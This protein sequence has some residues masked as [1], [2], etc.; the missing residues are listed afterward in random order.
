MALLLKHPHGTM[1]WRYIYIPWYRV[2]T[3]YLFDADVEATCA[4]DTALLSTTE[5]DRVYVS[6]NGGAS[7]TVLPTD[8]TNGYD[9]GAFTAGQRKS[10]RF[11]VNIPSGT[12]R[13][14]TYGLVIG[15]GT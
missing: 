5:A 1:E 9:L 12:H 14:G 7:Y 11:K 4:H 15:E 13:E 8:P 6:V 10:Y 3:D 2:G